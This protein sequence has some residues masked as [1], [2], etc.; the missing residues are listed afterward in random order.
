MSWLLREGDVLAAVEDRRPGWQ[1]GLTGAVLV[2]PPAL[3]H[4]WKGAAS[5]DLAWCIRVRTDD[6]NQCFEV[7][8][9]SRLAPHRVARPRLSGAIVAAGLGAF[10]RWHLQVGDRLEVRPADD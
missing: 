8:R 9:I 7:R 5:L 3:L 2:S 10:E 4:T 1:L 6:G